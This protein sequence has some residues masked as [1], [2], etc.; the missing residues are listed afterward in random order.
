MIRALIQRLRQTHRTAAYPA[1]PPVLPARY[2]G[3]PEIAADRCA[4]DCAACLAACPTGALC[5]AEGAVR[6]ESGVDADELKKGDSA[7]YRADVPH[8]ESRPM[9]PAR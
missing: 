3:R 6:L 1:Q 2:R 5:R 8:D 4:A 7:T 9:R